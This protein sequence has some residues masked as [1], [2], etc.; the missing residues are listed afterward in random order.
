M[1]AWRLSATKKDNERVLQRLMIEFEIQGGC[2]MKKIMM[3]VYAFILF[4]M[5]ACSFRPHTFEIP[6][7]KKLQ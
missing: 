2:R 7:A 4:S 3:V 6:N 5:V 1:L